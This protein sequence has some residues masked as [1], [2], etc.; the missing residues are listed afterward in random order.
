MSDLIVVTYPDQYK[1]AQVLAAL[2]RL[3]KAL[4]IEME[5][6]AFVVKETDGKVKLHETVSLARIGAKS[7]FAHGTLWGALVGLLFLQPA[8]GAVAGA[9]LGATS[10]AVGG[11]SVGAAT[12]AIAGKLAD[13]GIP[14]DFAKQLGENLNNGTSALFVLVRRAAP[15]KVLAEVKKYGGTVAHS[16]LSADAEQRLQSALSAG[17]AA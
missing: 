16:T 10:G 12:G 2:Q 17:T 6:M 14:N 7:G 11:A 9:A 13:Y 3:E 15:D 4:L 8:L 1:A 5:D